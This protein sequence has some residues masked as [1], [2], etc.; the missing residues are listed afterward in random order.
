[1]CSR[2]PY[3]DLYVKE[4]VKLEMGREGEERMRSS[5]A[6]LEEIWGTRLLEAVI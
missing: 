1:M 5:L 3:Y 6:E 2:H 4:K